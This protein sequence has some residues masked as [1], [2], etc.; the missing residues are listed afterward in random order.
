[1]L[2]AITRGTEEVVMQAQVSLE[3]EGHARPWWRMTDSKPSCNGLLRWLSGTK[4][5]IGIA[6]TLEMTMTDL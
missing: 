4:K 2:C 6:M 5:T 1:M 3:Y